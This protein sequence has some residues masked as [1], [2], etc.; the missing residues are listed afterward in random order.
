MKVTV[1]SGSCDTVMP[2]AEC[3]GI[4]IDESD[5]S[6]RGEEYEVANGE[7]IPNLGERRCLMMTQ[8]SN[9]PKRID[10]QVA[11]VHKALLSVTRAAD[12]GFECHLGR[13]G[14]HMLD[15]ITQEKIPIERE[16]NL[17]TMSVWVRPFTRRE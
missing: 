3:Q 6:K 15:T 1:D 17:Y 14:G 13:R 2:T 7:S 10:F 9:V 12:M 4:P 5:L 16:G 8:G 11:D